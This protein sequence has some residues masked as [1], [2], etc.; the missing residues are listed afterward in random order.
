M[1]IMVSWMG[2]AGVGVA[3]VGGGGG[4]CWEFSFKH[5][6]TDIRNFSTL[7]CTN[8]SNNCNKVFFLEM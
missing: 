4:G 5:Y 8:I 6:F 7:H 1:G 2:V 3:G